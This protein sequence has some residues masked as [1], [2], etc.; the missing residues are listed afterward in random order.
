M[1][2]ITTINR[3]TIKNIRVALDA[4]LEELSQELGIKITSGNARYGD[5]TGSFKIDLAAISED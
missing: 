1:T 2:Q 5:T 4:K 3:A